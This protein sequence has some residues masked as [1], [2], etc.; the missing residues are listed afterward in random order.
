MLGCVYQMKTRAVDVTFRVILIV[1]F[2]KFNKGLL[3]SLQCKSDFCN[4]QRFR[5]RREKIRVIGF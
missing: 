4:K 3:F 1:E 2:S 5:G